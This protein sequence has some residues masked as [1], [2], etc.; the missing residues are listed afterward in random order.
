MVPAQLPLLPRYSRLEFSIGTWAFTFSWAVVASTLLY[1][2]ALG[3]TSAGKLLSYLVLAA[4]TLLVGGIAVR[5]AT[6]LL[7]RSL[8]P[9]PPIGAAPPAAPTAAAP[10]A[11]RIH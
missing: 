5:P 2:I 3:H 7:R 11:A 10:A 9:P 4:I 6:A 1:W 8:P